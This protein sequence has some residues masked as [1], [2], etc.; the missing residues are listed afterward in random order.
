ML[1]ELKLG[2]FTPLVHISGMFSAM[3]GCC[4]YILPIAQHPTNTNAV[5]VVDLNK[6]LTQLA[7]LS[8]EE[9]QTYLYT[10]TDNLP[11]GINRPPIKLIH[12]N[13]CP[14]VASA[15]TLTAERAKELG[16]DAKQCRKSMDFF[17]ANNELVDKLID[18]FNTDAKSKKDQQPEQ[19]LYSGGFASANDKAESKT[20]TSLA[21][22]QVA[23]FQPNFDDPNLDAL[24]RRYK[25][26]NYPLSLSSEEQEKWARH[27][28]AYLIEHSHAYVERLNV[29]A[30]EHQH[31]PEKIEVLQKLGHY[32][33]FLSDGN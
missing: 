25:A 19:K 7:S 17:S 31:S 20:I 32:L 27:R 1:N 6:D 30:I 5:I 22:Q 28:E 16:V 24:W 23:T 15:K 14:I 12:I 9:L 10:A 21:P 33:A 26:R 8:V 4:S 13:K 29:L 2:T 18:V 3:Q 11:E